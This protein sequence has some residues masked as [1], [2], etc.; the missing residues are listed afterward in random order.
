MIKV[1]DALREAAAALAPT[2]PTP[3]LDA[4]LLMA[5]SMGVTRSHLLLQGQGG[6][7]PELFSE[8]LERRKR[9]EPVAYIV[10]H[11][12]FY[13]REFRVTRDTLIPRADS[14]TLIA[15]AL[16]ERPEAKRVLDLGTGTG[17]LLLTF[18][19]ETGASGVGLDRS[20]AAID[21]AVE[22]TAR[23]GMD[24]RVTLTT[25]DWHQP[26]W[27]KNLGQFDVILCNPPYVELGARLESDV[28][29]YEP[30]IALFA[31]ED[32][33]DDY[34]ILIPELRNLLLPDG[35]IVLEIGHQ[36]DQSV[37]QIA[38]GSGFVTE[39]FRDLAHRP[40]ALLLK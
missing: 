19:A 15:A 35:I 24:N 32:G 8:I 28:S 18:V 20:A 4:E 5:H 3:R 34:R 33:L 25:G 10:G 6:T 13:G 12:E 1:A 27:A 31:G 16:G 23:L 40:R 26:G 21:V 37:A 7:P 14:E 36:Q 11:Q 2:S 39:L 30:A 9:S 17:A 38:Q 22:N 29:D